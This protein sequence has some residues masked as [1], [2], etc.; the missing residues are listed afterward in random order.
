MDHVRPAERNLY[1]GMLSGQVLNVTANLSGEQVST[2]RV[3]QD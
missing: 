3:G 1:A 2:G